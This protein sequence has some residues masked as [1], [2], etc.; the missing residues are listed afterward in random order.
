MESQG[1]AFLERVRQGFL[2]EA[3]RKPERIHV[4]DASLTVDAVHQQI[5]KIVAAHL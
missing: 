4:V 3:S 1:L 2:D 5:C